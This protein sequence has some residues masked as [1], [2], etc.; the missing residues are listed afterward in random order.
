MRTLAVKV[1]TKPGTN[2]VA[3]KY[4]WPGGRDFLQAYNC[5]VVDSAHQVIVASPATNLTPD[6]RQGMSGR[7]WQ[8]LR[9][10]SATPALS[11][12]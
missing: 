5:Q 9:K 2:S 10:P 12:G 6:E 8:W 3:E 11:P 7:R 1:S 4:R